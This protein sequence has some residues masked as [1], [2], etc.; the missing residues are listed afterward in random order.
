MFCCIG[1][2]SRE[3]LAHRHRGAL[4]WYRIY[5]TGPENV[6]ALRKQC[7]LSAVTCHDLC[8]VL[9]TDSVR[10]TDSLLCYWQSAEYTTLVF[11]AAAL[12]LSARA[13]RWEQLW[14]CSVGCYMLH[15]KYLSLFC[16][17]VV[18]YTS[19][20]QPGV[21]VPLEVGEDILGALENILRGM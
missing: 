12:S 16:S 19:G 18:I 9:I 2:L 5:S 8:S 3:P 11:M 21:R 14:I 17:S 13:R 15:T 7:H 1:V 20:I 10:H 6:I 4:Q